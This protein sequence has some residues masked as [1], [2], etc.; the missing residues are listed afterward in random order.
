MVTAAAIAVLRATALGDCGGGSCNEDGCCNSEGKD[1]GN[2][3]N[4]IGDNCPC[5]PRHYPLCHPQRLCQCQCLLPMPLPTLSPATLLPTSLP[6]LS[7][8]PLHLS[9]CNKESDDKGDKSDDNCNE[10]CD[11]DGGKSNGNSKEE[12]NDEAGKGDGDGD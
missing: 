12:S 11:G 2:G 3:G 7:L 9:A 4:G 8:L 6:M 1:S 10:E 5:H